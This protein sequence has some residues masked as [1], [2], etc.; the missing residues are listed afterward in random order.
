MGGLS[1]IKI[2]IATKQLIQVDVQMIEQIHQKA[3]IMLGLASILGG[4]YK[5]HHHPKNHRQ[6]SIKLFFHRFSFPYLQSIEH[7]ILKVSQR[8]NKLV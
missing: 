4:K 7:F 8:G 2:C 3:I 5:N 1:H 6:P